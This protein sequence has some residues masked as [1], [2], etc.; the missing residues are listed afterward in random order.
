MKVL[1]TFLVLVCG[2]C[3]V[4]ATAQLVNPGWARWSVM[5]D[6]SFWNGPVQYGATGYRYYPVNG[7]TAY[8]TSM[9]M[10]ADMALRQQ[11]AAQNQ[12]A[13]AA[14]AQ[15]AQ[16]E[17]N[18]NVAQYNEMRRQQRAAV[19]AKRQADKDAMRASAANR[20]APKKQTELYPRLA[21]DQLD[22]ATG[23]IHWPD[24]LTGPA[25]AD[26][27]SKIE[28]ALK[29]QAKNG[30]SPRSA[31]IIF[32]ASRDMRTQLS[33]DMN[34]IGFESY[35]STRKFLNSLALEGDHAMEALK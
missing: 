14:A 28:D 34:T 21:A 12:A 27:R 20:P 2:L 9:R 8:S 29:D 22:P 25:Y 32:D 10:Q 7:D 26:D 4:Q 33:K 11:E 18:A 3:A 35:S 15:Q 5:S 1:K 24:A 16:Q 6:P 31:S 23:T 19:E 13:A 17:Y 30:P